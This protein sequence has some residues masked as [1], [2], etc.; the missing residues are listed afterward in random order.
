MAITVKKVQLLRCQLQNRPGSLAESLKPFAEAR[1][2]L[3]V[4]MGYVYEKDRRHAALE[5]FGPSNRTTSVAKGRFEAARHVHCLVVQGDD[6]PGLGY[7]IARAMGS[8]R[9]NMSFAVMQAIGNRYAAVFGFETGVAATRAMRVI[10]M[11]S[12]LRK[13]STQSKK[14]VS[15]SKKARRR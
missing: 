8:S 11:A 5:V 9:I 13:P 4:I 1:V 7:E 15:S 6:R 3:Q 10:K 12:A 2:N 14:K